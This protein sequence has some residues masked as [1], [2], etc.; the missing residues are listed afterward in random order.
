MLTDAEIMAQVFAAFREEQAEHRQAAGDLLLEL[1]REPDHPQRQAILD[2]L[3][4]EAHS[5]KGGARAAG[6]LEIE[7]LAHRIEDIFSAV[8]RGALKLTPEV[9]DPVYAALDAIGEM[10]NEIVA[11]RLAHLDPYQPLMATLGAFVAQAEA[12]RTA[13]KAER[14][15]QAPAPISAHGKQSGDEAPHEPEKQEAPPAAR[16]VPAPAPAPTANGSGD[17]IWSEM[18]NSTVRLSTATLDGLLNEAGELMTCTIRARQNA[19]EAN[20]I[21]ELPNRWRRI[22]RQTHPVISRLQKQAPALRPTVHHLDNRSEVMAA[23][24]TTTTERDTATLLEALTQANNL[25][26]EL[27]GRLALQARQASED[28][29]RLA[30][31]TDRLHDQ[32]RRTR[33]LPLTTLFN[34]LRLQLREMAR[35]A[36]KQIVL[37]LDDGGAEADRQVLERLREVL[38]HLLRNAVDHGIECADVRIARG[39]PAQGR[40]TLCAAISGDHLSLT[41]EDDGAGLNLEAIRQ[42]AF[43]SGIVSETDMLRMSDAEI[44]DLIFLPGF[45][46]KQ[47]VSE[48]SGRGV[49]LDIVRSHVERMHGRVGVRSQPGAGATFIL[50]VPLSLTS[51]HGLLLMAGSSSY[52]LPLDSVQRII[53]IEPQAIQILEGRA[54]LMLDNRPIALVNLADMLGEEGSSATLTSGSARIQRMALILGSGER[55]IACMIDGVLG[56]QELVVHR[57]PNPLQRVRFIGGATI[58]ADGSI[59]PILDVVDVVRAAIGVRRPIAITPQPSAPRRNPV[60]L[61]VDDSITTRTLEKNILEAAGYQVRLA[62]DGAEALD[63]LQQL[64]DNGGCD[65]LISD[66]DMPRLNGFDLTTKVR[67]ST[68]FQ[69]LP[70]ILVTSLDTAADRERGIAAGA[71]AYIVK[72][73]FD[74]QNLLDTIAQLI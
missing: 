67:G 44:A 19:R 43:S 35:S 21:A 28:H 65:L 30:A 36:G 13:P 57:L 33:M 2:Q 37:D 39:K 25:I 12:I 9:C 61:V 5:L 18:S 34:P 53:Q 48:L 66:I 7:Q 17:G 64:V 51:S 54:A 40:I 11:G 45:S 8:R 23:V 58:M 52:V 32:V 59:I 10:M 26:A 68:R 60:I 62:T 29:A 46:T 49:G 73:S 4:R 72:R 1:E 38:I 15:D 50:S 55:Q 27:E 14:P 71:D 41:L 69:H 24:T 22:W 16:P 47:I 20:A 63:M 6:Q 70:I 3:F 56:E 42:R 31:V 74:Q